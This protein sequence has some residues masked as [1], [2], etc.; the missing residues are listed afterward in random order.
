MQLN[1]WKAATDQE[2]MTWSLKFEADLGMVCVCQH[3][4][5]EVVAAGTEI[6]AL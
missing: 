1:L 6:V 3:L 2:D 4:H 5:H